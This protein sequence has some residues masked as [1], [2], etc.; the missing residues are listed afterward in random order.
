MILRRK[1]I[2]AK[3][4]TETAETTISLVGERTYRGE[5]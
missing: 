1:C 3:H 2:G 5:A 4:S